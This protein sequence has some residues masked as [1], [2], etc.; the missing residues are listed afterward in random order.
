MGFLGQSQ[1]QIFCPVAPI[2]AFGLVKAHVLIFFWWRKY[3]LY[4]C[5]SSYPQWDWAAKLMRVFFNSARPQN[6][7]SEKYWENEGTFQGQLYP[8]SKALE[9][10]LKNILFGTTVCNINGSG[11]YLVEVGDS[12]GRTP[13]KCPLKLCLWNLSL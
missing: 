1:F 12:T 5:F 6:F 4:D 10:V 2:S 8:I 3:V 13:Q 7:L 11:D 9:Q